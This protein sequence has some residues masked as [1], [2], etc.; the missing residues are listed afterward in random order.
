MSLDEFQRL[1]AAA[2]QRT[3]PNMKIPGPRREVF[4]L[5]LASTGFRIRELGS[6]KPDSFDVVDG[7]LTISLEA[8]RAKNRKRARRVIPQEIR[9]AVTALLKETPQG[10]RLFPLPSK[11]AKALERDLTA[12]RRQ[13]IAEAETDEDRRAREES[14]FLRYRTEDGVFADNHAFRAMYCTWVQRFAESHR[15]VLEAQRHADFRTAQRYWADED[16]EV[17]AVQRRIG[18]ELGALA[19]GPRPRAGEGEGG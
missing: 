18:Q 10:E 13:W 17:D 9:G 2:R 7:D 5:L 14:T 19:L 1:L 12:A 11:P 16:R 6:V 3:R 8:A 4:Y 15:S